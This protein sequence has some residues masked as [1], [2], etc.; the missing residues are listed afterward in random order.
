MCSNSVII[1]TKKSLIENWRAEVETHSHLRARILGQDRNANF[2]ALNSPAR[3]YLMHYEA[4]VSERGR[5]ELFLKTRR[6]GALLDE[7]QKIKNPDAAVSNALHK[8]REGFV[9]R[10]IMTGTPVANRPY[11]IWSPVKFLDGG[12]A[13][14]DN[15]ETFK[16]D[17]ELSNDLR[18]S[19]KKA[20]AL[21][22]ALEAVM[23]KTRAFSV[24]ETKSTAELALPD[25]IVRNELCDL[26]P[27]QAVLYAHYHEDMAALVRQDGRS[28]LDEAEGALKQLLRLV[29]VASNPIM[30]DEGYSEMPGKV[31]HLDRIVADVVARGEKVIVWTSFTENAEFIAQHLHEYGAV[32]VHGQLSMTSREA[33]LA[34]FKTEEICRILVATPGAAKEGLTLTVANH[35]IFF[36]RSFSLDDY[37]QAQDRIHRISQ[38]RECTIVNL[39]ARGTVDEWVDALLNAKHLAA[40]LAQGDI[41]REE[42]DARADY[43][44]GDMIRDVLMSDGTVI[45]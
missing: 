40:Q 32:L 3:I 34:R 21:A 6:V 24:R 36:D 27:R 39:V 7:A 29:Q 1:V 17:L 8:L 16:T 14:G 22:Q 38:L 18:G 28:I 2:Y 4:V 42:Y 35:A 19:T 25:K 20:T 41:E 44:F 10:V 45:K 37:L 43:S 33:A 12:E 13:L 15:F 26:E 5:L 9:R 31:P 23:E 30:L 11:D